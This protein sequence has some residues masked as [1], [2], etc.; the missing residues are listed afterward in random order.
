MTQPASIADFKANF[1][2]D[3][4]FGEGM[5][6]VRDADIT[7]ALNMADMVFNVDLWTGTAEAKIAFLYAAAHFLVLNLQTSGGLSDQFQAGVDSNGGG[8][9]LNKS[10]GQVSVAYQLPDRLAND[11]ILY[12]LQRTGYGQQ[13]LQLVTPRLVGAG[14]AVGGWRESD[15]E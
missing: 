2:R 9:I 12:Q 8:V 10:V 3:F 14:Y 6:T 7:K 11:Q 5:E 15:L 4:P 13:Y 1:D